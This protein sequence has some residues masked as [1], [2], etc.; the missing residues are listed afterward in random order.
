MAYQAIARKF[1]P[2]TFEDVVGQEHLTRTIRNAIRDNRL[3][4]AYL[5]SGARG[6]G[7]TTMARL[8]AKALNCRKGPTVEPC[9]E[10]PSCREISESGATLDVQEIDAASHTSIDNVREVIIGTVAISPARDRYR[11]FIIDEVHRLSKPAFDAL[12]KTVEEPPPNVVF[13]LATTAVHE[14]PITILSRCQHFEF[15]QIPTE[16]IFERL[17]LIAEKEG[18]DAESEAVRMVARAAAGSMRDGQS[19]LDQVISYAGKKIT[20]ADVAEVL[21][22]VSE[23]ALIN[24]AE[25]I[26]RADVRELLRLVADLVHRGME[27]RNFCREL[28]GIFRDL[29]VLRV[30]GDAALLQAPD[31]S[32]AVLQEI[33]KRFTEQELIRCFHVLTRVEQDVKFS[34]DQRFALEMGLAK[35]ASVRNLEALESIAARLSQLEERTGSRTAGGTP[36]N[37][38]APTPSTARERAPA[39]PPKRATLPASTAKSAPLPESP[40]EPPPEPPFE[41][42]EFSGEVGASDAETGRDTGNVLGK[43]V[44][45]VEAKGK[46]LIGVALEKAHAARASGDEVVIQFPKA[47]ESAMETL[48]AEASRRTL[49]EVCRELFGTR[50]SLR[51]ETSTPSAPGPLAPGESQRNDPRERVRTN[52]AVQQLVRKFDGEITA[53]RPPAGAKG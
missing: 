8:L 34:D 12:L 47:A 53:V 42:E 21:G 40:P 33:S 36:R 7:K 3:H 4:H 15:K 51:Y 35:L 41:P 5:F 38:N 11:I 19:A 31:S 14:V 48:E 39:A 37:T 16:K 24:F 23:E 49:H 43:I 1:R 32:H 17:K 18:I 52:P 26:D 2:Q 25:A 6:V 22:L 28:M 20:Q 50:V 46:I 29:L 13:V 45:A 30:S 44:R 10:C 9:G 27:L